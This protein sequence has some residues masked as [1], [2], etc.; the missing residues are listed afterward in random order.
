MSVPLTL[1][2]L[3][4]A[5]G[6]G[7]AQGRGP[8]APSYPAQSGSAPCVCKPELGVCQEGG[9][10]EKPNFELNQ[11]NQTPSTLPAVLAYPFFFPNPK[12]LF[13]DSLPFCFSSPPARETLTLNEA[14]L[15]VTHIDKLGAPMQF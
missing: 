8:K 10:T 13:S 5:Q 1:A 14:E 12:S 3:T 6:P 2:T 15:A 4:K 9:C 7:T 11:T